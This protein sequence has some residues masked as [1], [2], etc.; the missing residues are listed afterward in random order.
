MYSLFTNRGDWWFCHNQFLSRLV[1]EGDRQ[2]SYW[3]QVRHL[4][5]QNHG[6]TRLPGSAA[7]GTCGAGWACESL[8]GPVPDRV[9]LLSGPHNHLRNTVCVCV[10][11]CVLVTQSCLVLTTP[12][13]VAD[14]TPLSIG[15][16]RQEY[17]SEWPFPSPGDLPNKIFPTHLSHQ[18]RPSETLL[19][20]MSAAVS[21]HTDDFQPPSSSQKLPALVSSTPLTFTTYQ[22]PN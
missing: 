10:C 3:F 4:L 2:K 18:W 8:E 1:E 14:Y 7:S 21:F 11:V 5:H 13:T 17:W 9:T 15:F 20:P 16:S 12:E 19:L 6:S 22:N